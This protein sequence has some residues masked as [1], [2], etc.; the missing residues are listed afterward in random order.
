MHNF[1]KMFAILG[2]F[3]HKDVGIS[4][5][6]L[7]RD[8]Y[9]QGSLLEGEDRFEERSDK[10][11]HNKSNIGYFIGLLQKALHNIPKLL[12]E[13]FSILEKA[14]S[15]TDLSHLLEVL[16]LHQVASLFHQ[17]NETCY[18]RFGCFYKNENM[19]MPYGGPQSP[20]DVGMTFYYFNNISHHLEN[21]L[22][23][24][25]NNWTLE[26]M[27]SPD[28]IPLIVLTHG[29]KGGMNVSSWARP[30]VMALLENVNC[31]IIFAD[32]T[33]GAA[34]PNYARVAANAPMAGAIISSLIQQIINAT[35]CKLTPDNVTIVGSSLGAQTAGFAG[36]HFKRTTGLQLGRITGLDPG[37]LLFKGTNLSLSKDDAAF[38]DIIHT[39]NGELRT[40]K[41]GMD[42][43]IGHV[44]F[45][46]N[47]GSLQD[48]CSPYP[49]L[50]IDK[51][52][53]VSSVG[54]LFVTLL[55]STGCSHARAP[56]LYIESIINHTCNFTSVPCDGGWQNFNSCYNAFKDNETVRGLM[57]FYSNTREGRGD[58]YLKTSNSSPFCIPES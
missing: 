40:F 29:F 19:S 47:G 27:T 50:T 15:I 31:N 44:D 1:C 34:P 48:G 58:Q 16:V 56:N 23:W 3:L 18:E 26:N 22:I 24:T 55:V 25:L 57:G 41:Y 43:S 51:L 5:A 53:N 20:E 39:N 45:Y 8:E 9:D 37:N 49:Q 12:K 52:K 6:D 54:E 11:S 28:S 10:V 13:V 7:T 42:R 35:E 36:R 32:W 14:T 38:V 46:P 2:M 17:Q 30:L 21:P 33:N 4:L